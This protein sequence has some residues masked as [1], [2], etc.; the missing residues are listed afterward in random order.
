MVGGY[1]LQA[2][3]LR[4]TRAGTSAFLTCAGTLLAA[5]WAWP[6]L[7]Q[8]PGLRLV[9]GIAIAM[10]GSALLSLRGGSRSARARP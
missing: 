5:F 9:A 4:S 7:G 8:R 10:A 1:W 3:G 6:L 2:V